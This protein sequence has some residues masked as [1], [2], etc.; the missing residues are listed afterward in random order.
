M[1]PIY[2]PYTYISDPVAGALAACFGRFS[3]YQ[4]L[5]DLLPQQM[6]TWVDKGA[7][8]IIVPGSG[9]EQ[10][11]E[12]AA[13]N[14]LD[15]ANL[16]TGGTGTS[17]SAL[18]TLKATAPY[19]DSSLSS[20][21]VADVKGQMQGSLPTKAYDPAS[22]AKIF[23]YFAQEYDRQSQELDQDMEEFSRWERDLIKELKVEDDVL[24]SGLKDDHQQ[25]SA[26]AEDYLIDG[27]MLAWTRLYLVDKAPSG[28]LVT[29]S[30]TIVETL[31]DCAPQ[32]EKIILFDAL[33]LADANAD[34]VKLWQDQLLTYLYEIV[35]NTSSAPSIDK[36]DKLTVA[37][38][39]ASVSLSIFLVPKQTPH[40]L[41]SRCVDAKLSEAEKAFLK[42]NFKNTLIGLVEI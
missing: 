33:P 30:K 13:Q 36:I 42:V 28:I 38:G 23:L 15:W 27:R 17:L 22:A 12:T 25:V 40:E 39:E 34:E 31:L 10:K 6:K 4:P 37:A 21:I 1:T 11:L 7:I 2:F 3:L 35:D 41:L 32:T 29:Q 5:P 8:D 20:Q 24:P 14:Y 19:L 26:T 16:H 18:K 9:D